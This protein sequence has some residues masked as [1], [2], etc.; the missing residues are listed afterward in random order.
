[1]KSGIGSLLEGQKYSLPVDQDTDLP[2]YKQTESH[3]VSV[4]KALVLWLGFES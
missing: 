4:D 2:S 3:A 1:M